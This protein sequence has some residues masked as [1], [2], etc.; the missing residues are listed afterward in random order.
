[1]SIPTNNL[2]L[3][4]QVN[5]SSFPIGAYTQSYGLESYVVYDQIK[6]KEDAL[7][8]IL[9]NL[10]TTMS[11]TELLAVSLSFDY[12]KANQIDNLCKLDK[13]LLALKSAKEIRDASLKLGSRFA[14]AISSMDIAF[15][16]N[17]NLLNYSV[18]YGALWSCIGISKKTAL[19]F[20]IY[21]QTSA[22]VTNCVKL[23]PLSQTA[24]QQILYEIS[25]E[26]DNII[27]N[28]FSMNESDLGLSTPAL[29]IRCMQHEILYSRLYMS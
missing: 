27:D 25:K 4:M 20:Y 28:V 12:T 17:L 29:D 11:Y 8:Y 26:Y 3:L 22:M 18:L 13:K 24:G 9:T 16:K 21:S 10:K 23:V 5:D 7:N 2:Y 15:L 1:M 19:S 14:K 6:T